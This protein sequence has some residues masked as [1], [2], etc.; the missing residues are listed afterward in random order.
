MKEKGCI[1]TGRPEILKYEN[2]Y[3]KFGQKDRKPWNKKRCRKILHLYRKAGNPKIRK[4][5]RSQVSSRQEVKKALNER[6]CRICLHPDR[7]VE[8]KKI[9]RGL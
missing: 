9:K 2:I 5:V 3:E 7:K 8:N 1:R 6:K 4:H